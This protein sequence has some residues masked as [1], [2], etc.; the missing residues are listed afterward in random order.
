MILAAGRGER[1][2]PL[3]D[4]VPKPM[5]EVGGRPLIEWHAR[6]LAAAGVRELV[7]N[8][9]HLGDQIERHLADGAR[10]GVTIRYSREPEALET[11]GGIAFARPLLGDAPFLLVNADVYTDYPLAE[12]I[13]AAAR[14]AAGA[15]D[16]LMVLVP[17]PAHHARGDFALNGELAR[18]DGAPRL[19]YA[20]IALMHPRL[21]ADVAAGS[22]APL[23][24]RLRSAAAQG[25]LLARRYD[26]LWFDVGTTE[27]LEQ[28][29]A[30]AAA[31]AQ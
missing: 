18:L 21:V 28:A 27:R 29:R 24:P 17:N 12:L 20:G 26:G 10:F 4:R 9:A 19:T 25:R 31:Q 7:I 5:L 2:R 3:T 15:A 23:G 11:A 14:L 8:H 6:R 1:L 16:A 30:A 22:R 13:P